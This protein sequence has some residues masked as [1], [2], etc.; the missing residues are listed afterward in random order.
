MPVLQGGQARDDVRFEER[1]MNKVV[2]LISERPPQMPDSCE[3]ALSRDQADFDTQ[4]VGGLVKV[5]LDFLEHS[6]L[7]GCSPFLEAG[8]HLQER[9][10]GAT[11]TKAVDD[12]QDSNRPLFRTHRTLLQGRAVTVAWLNR[13][14]GASSPAMALLP[15]G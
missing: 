7:D 15:A 9:P 4:V 12:R 3:T 14:V 8:N 13:A 10:L 5:G 11:W 2:V 6:N 1:R